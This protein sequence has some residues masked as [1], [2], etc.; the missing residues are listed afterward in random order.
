M[1]QNTRDAKWCWLNGILSPGLP[2]VHPSILHSIVHSFHLPCFQRTVYAWRARGA[3]YTDAAPACRER[4]SAKRGTPSLVPFLPSG[5][6][7]PVNASCHHGPQMPRVHVFQ[8]P[9]S[10]PA[11]APQDLRQRPVLT[12]RVP[13]SPLHHSADSPSGNDSRGT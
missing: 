8:T 12:S 4:E 11:L 10:T 2:L 5:I 13:L 1:P 3:N 6:G 7:C 9:S